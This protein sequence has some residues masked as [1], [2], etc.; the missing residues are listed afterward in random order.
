[1]KSWN[2]NPIAAV[3]ALICAVALGVGGS[4]VYANLSSE[5]DAAAD[6]ASSL[7]YVLNAGAGNL[8]QNEAN[9]Y[10][11]TLSE[12]SESIIWFTDRPERLADSVSTARFI[13]SWQKLGFTD[14]P[15]NITMTLVPADGTSAEMTIV[16]TL[17]NPVYDRA[18]GILTTQLVMILEEDLRS[19]GGELDLEKASSEAEPP[20]SFEKVTV[21]ID[22]S[23][24]VDENGEL[25]LC[26]NDFGQE[27]VGCTTFSGDQMRELCESNADCA[28]NL[29]A[30]GNLSVCYTNEDC[31]FYPVDALRELCFSDEA[32]FQ[33]T[34]IYQQEQQELSD[35]QQL[36]NC[37]LNETCDYSEEDFGVIQLCD[38]SSPCQST[39]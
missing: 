3:V 18:A 29:D 15:P 2:L 26:T 24:Y 22:N 30:D 23:G 6:N 16:A 36:N 13:D 39:K 27:N 7:M 35:E 11:M 10:T 4:L 20:T 14:D 37:L 21:F 38:S 8:V 19:N 9:K 12:T 5:P 1:M 34:Q 32:C 31:G 17:T 33:Y 28:R 25:V